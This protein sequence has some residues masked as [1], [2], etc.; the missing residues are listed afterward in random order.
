M[1]PRPSSAISSRSAARL[2]ARR[3][4]CTSAARA[5]RLTFVSASCAIQY[6]ATSTAAGSAGTEAGASTVTDV[7]GEDSCAARPRSEADEPELVERRRAQAVDQPADVGDHRLHLLGGRHEQLVGA[8]QIR[9]G[10]VADGLEREREPGQGRPEAVVQVAPDPPPLLLAQ[11]DDA[12]PRRPAAPAR[13]RRRGRRLRPAARG[14]R[15]AGGHARGAARPAAARAA[16]RR[17]PRP[18]GRAGRR[19]LSRPGV[20]YSATPRSSAPSPTSDPTYCSASVCPTVSTTPGSTASGRSELARRPAEPCDRG[21]GVVALA[22]HE[23]VDE[24]LHALAQR[25]EARRRR[26]RSRRARRRGRRATRAARRSGR[27]R[28]RSFRRRR[29]SSRRRRAARLT[30]RSIS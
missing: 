5:C 26:R 7:V 10:Q 28:R 17:R 18:G 6:A 24:A 22:V 25:L 1:S 3:E 30:T 27:R 20:P 15:S 4:R 23:P 8:L 9:R 2:D 14:R 13:A 12:L 16:A 11:L 29:S 21:V 19:G